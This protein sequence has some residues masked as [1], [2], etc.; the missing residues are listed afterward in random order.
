M[1][2]SPFYPHTPPI[3]ATLLLVDV[4]GLHALAVDYA[5]RRK[6]VFSLGLPNDVREGIVE[7]LKH[8]VPFSLPK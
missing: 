4:E 7:L 2:F 8:T 3:I 6:I 5:H 1:A